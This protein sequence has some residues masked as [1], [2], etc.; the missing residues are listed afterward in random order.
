MHRKRFITGSWL[1]AAM[2]ASKPQDLHDELAGGRPRKAEPGKLL[3]E[4]RGLRIR[5]ASNSSS[6]LRAGDD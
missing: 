2:E 6:S 3:S 1:D 4:L 5:V